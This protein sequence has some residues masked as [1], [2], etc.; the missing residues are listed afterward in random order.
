MA[1]R[2]GSTLGGQSRRQSASKRTSVASRRASTSGGMSQGQGLDDVIRLMSPVSI[3]TGA[4]SVGDS[5]G[6]EPVQS[7][8]D[9]SKIP[10]LFKALEHVER[11][12]VLNTYHDKLLGYMNFRA[13]EVEP[14]PEPDKVENPVLKK[15]TKK[16]KPEASLYP[17]AALKEFEEKEDVT[18]KVILPQLEDSTATVHSLWEFQCDLTD[19]R[20]ISCMTW[21]KANL[22]LIAVGYGE[23][24]FGKQRDGMIAFWSLKNPR[25]P[26]ATIPTLSGVTSLDFATSSP[27]LLAVGFYNGNVAIYDVRNP[28]DTEPMVKS[29]FATG[30]HADPVWKVQWVDHTAEHGEALVSISTDGRVS[31]WS[32]KKVML[33]LKPSYPAFSAM[34]AEGHCLSYSI[35][36]C[37]I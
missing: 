22:N 27:S 5:Q 35:A 12:C 29:S 2:R 13:R 3:V 9:I 6:S 25:Y 33:I 26:H 28:R 14:P 23:F 37:K 15:K 7:E 17:L 1:S 11:A 32:I 21:N 19:G 30:K 36:R 18:L 10:G 16:V 31:Q 20:N 8:V 4:G 34:N 24:E